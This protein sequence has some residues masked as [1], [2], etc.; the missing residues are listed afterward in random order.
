M[1]TDKIFDEIK[2]IHKNAI[3]KATKETMNEINKIL[4]VVIGICIGL[5]VLSIL[6]LMLLS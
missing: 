5:S 4:N 2:I 1:D 3:E 6:I